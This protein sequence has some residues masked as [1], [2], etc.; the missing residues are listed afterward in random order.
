MDLLS[1]DVFSPTFSIP[2]PSDWKGAKTNRKLNQLRNKQTWLNAFVHLTEIAL[3][4]YHIEGLD[5]T[6]DERVLLMSLLWY[7]RAVIFRK[8]GNMYA[9]P[10]INSSE[11]WTIYGRWKNGKWIALNGMSGDVKLMIPGETPFVMETPTGAGQASGDIGV[12]IRENPLCY[13]FITYCLQ[14]ADYQADTLR[15]LDTARVHL[16]HPYIISGQQ[17]T[18]D[19]IGAGASDLKD[20]Q[21]FMVKGAYDGDQIQVANLLN[22]EI[23]NEI[24][25]LYEWYEA[26]FKG[27]CGIAHAGGVDKKGEN[28]T[29]EELHIDDEADNTNL[30]IRLKQIQ[31][32]L[33]FANE[34]F[35]KS[36]RVVTEHEKELEEGAEDGNDSGISD[37]DNVGVQRQRNISVSD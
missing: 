1:V 3:D 27:L 33:D 4:R 22:S 11:G 24:R 9:L 32:D 21:D 7:G 20:N 34:I 18:I 37:E 28:V 13:P 30:Q 8:N 12:M 17:A 35:G 36:Y 15:T 26:R 14:Y 5:D 25:S 23:T 10:V 19:S 31:A 29:T 16:K 6:I 2:I